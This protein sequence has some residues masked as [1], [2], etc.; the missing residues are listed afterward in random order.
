MVSEMSVECTEV[1]TMAMDKFAS[2]S[3][4]EVSF[5][6][7]RCCGRFTWCLL[8]LFVLYDLCWAAEFCIDV[9]L[10]RPSQHVFA[11]LASVGSG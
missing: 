4:F 11:R 10:L 8:L 5:S 6:H 7:A 1:I 3:N 2:S 9:R